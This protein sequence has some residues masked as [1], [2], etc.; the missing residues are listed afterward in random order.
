MMLVSKGASSVEA[1]VVE[2]TASVVQGK[3]QHFRASAIRIDNLHQRKLGNARNGKKISA[4][5]H[6]RRTQ[7]IRDPERPRLRKDSGRS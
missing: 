7:A 2:R 1:S 6:F 3:S 4:S 5:S